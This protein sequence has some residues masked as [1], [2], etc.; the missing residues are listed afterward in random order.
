MPHTTRCRSCAKELPERAAHCPHCLVGTHDTDLYGDAC[1]GS[2]SP[3]SIW[4]K[5]D[6]K[7]ELIGRCNVCGELAS[8]PVEKEDNPTLLLSLANRPL[9]NPPFPI[10]KMEE[11][12]AAMGG[13]GDTGGYDA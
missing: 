6:G 5:P 8:S 11:M 13:S 7:W 4:V 12:T 2:L 1:G 9:A 10:E 3:I